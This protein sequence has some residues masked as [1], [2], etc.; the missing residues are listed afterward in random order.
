M[1]KFVHSVWNK[2]SFLLFITF[3]ISNHANN[4]NDTTHNLTNCSKS[5]FHN[6]YLQ[7][8]NKLQANESVCFC[9]MFIYQLQSSQLLIMVLEFF[10]YL[11]Q[12]HFILNFLSVSS[13]SLAQWVRLLVYSPVYAKSWSVRRLP[14]S[15]M[16]FLLWEMLI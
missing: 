11:W 12:N 6:L 3:K 7:I 4:I 8:T 14:T 2:N 1:H 5:N 15:R 13:T 9:F 16:V 10:Y